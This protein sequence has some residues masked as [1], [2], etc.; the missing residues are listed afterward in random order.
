MDRITRDKLVEE[1]FTHALRQTSI[2]K[3]MV[4]DWCD[5][6]SLA[7]EALLD[8]V[9]TYIPSRGTSLR[10]YVTKCVQNKMLDE[11]KHIR[12]DKA[13]EP[14]MIPLD[15]PIKAKGEK[16]YTIHDIV[17]SK[18][19][20][21]LDSL[22]LREEVDGLYDAI[23]HIPTAMRE[24]LITRYISDPAMSQ[25]EYAKQHNRTRAWVRRLEDAALAKCKEK[26]VLNTKNMRP[27]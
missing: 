6:Q 15:K 17:P 2:F 11:A 12:R 19:M 9:E 13:K 25:V 1:Y 18:E 16:Q 21:A 20:T 3:D 26:I 27:S 7:A 23:N 8:A 4:P 22:V 10:T 5:R 24:L 14:R